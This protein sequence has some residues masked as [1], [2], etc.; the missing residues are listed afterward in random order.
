MSNSDIKEQTS[1]TAKQILDDL[2]KKAEKNLHEMWGEDI[3][4]KPLV[5]I[6]S[7]LSD[8][9]GGSI[10]N[11]LTAKQMKAILSIK[12]EYK[13]IELI[14]G[15]EPVNI[16]RIFA[17]QDKKRW[18]YVNQVIE[19]SNKFVAAIN[20]RHGSLTEKQKNRLDLIQAAR[21]ELEK[22]QSS[23]GKH[24]KLMITEGRNFEAYKA[25]YLSILV[26]AMGGI[27]STN[28]KSGKDRT[29]IDE[30]YRHAMILYF[31]EKKKLPSFTDTGEDR[32]RFTE[33][34]THLF[35]TMK[36]QEA[37]SANT[38]GSFGLKD[39]AKM[40]C[41]DI[42]SALG[43]TYKAS[44][45]RAAMNKPQVFYEDE[46]RQHKESKVKYRT[47]DEQTFTAYTQPSNHSMSVSHGTINVNALPSK[48]RLPRKPLP[49]P[50]E[51]AVINRMQRLLDST[52][53]KWEEL[54]RQHGDKPHVEK[55][56]EEINEGLEKIKTWAQGRINQPLSSENQEELRT[57]F[58]LLKSLKDE[59]GE[60][61]KNN[62]PF[63]FRKK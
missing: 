27:V 34:F 54:N 9:L 16:L 3:G 20:S 25:A 28:C 1:F 23:K 32:Q 5:F 61:E 29:G 52:M 60:I 10:D 26:E 12:N 44:N 11:K 33:I 15:N 4:I 42:A 22:L 50:S 24:R 41:G 14:A 47:N 53:Q 51:E 2:T 43:K 38:P 40:I 49:K 46:K 30:I 62:N 45:E 63:K 17:I 37:A 36:A 13:G 6:Q 57:Q 18:E 48:P 55:F 21:I 35:N 8:T 56:S 31:E 19:Y 7:L 59:I 58:N 39:S